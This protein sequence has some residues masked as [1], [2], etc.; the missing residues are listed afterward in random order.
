MEECYM[1]ERINDKL[2]EIEHILEKILEILP[3][4]F[5]EYQTKETIK[6]ACERYFERIIE[7]CVDV[8]LLVIKE[9]KLVIPEG[10]IESFQSLANAKIISKKLSEKLQDAKR[11]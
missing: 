7:N 5:E 11:M 4:V 9:K 6:A 10:D 1:N 3:A 8:C 2:K